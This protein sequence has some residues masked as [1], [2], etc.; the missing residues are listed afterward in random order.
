MIT[1]IGSTFPQTRNRSK[2]DEARTRTRARRQRDMGVTN[3]GLQH[4][5]AVRPCPTVWEME[6]PVRG[7]G[8]EKR[9]ARQDNS[10]SR[11]ALRFLWKLSLKSFDCLRIAPFERRIHH[12]A[13]ATRFHFSAAAPG[14]DRLPD[15]LYPGAGQTASVT[16]RRTPLP[17]S[18]WPDPVRSS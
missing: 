14:P 18:R 15:S 5:D 4:F 10:V 7:A 8:S 12:F 9:I 3:R 17:G 6:D 16:S 1:E 11:K 2:R 13:K